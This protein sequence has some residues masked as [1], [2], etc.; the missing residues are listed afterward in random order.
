MN[1]LGHAVP[2]TVDAPR[3]VLYVR[4]STKEQLQGEGGTPSR[5]SVRHACDGR[6]H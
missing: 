5:R 4:V 6:R 3:A 1:K 2:L